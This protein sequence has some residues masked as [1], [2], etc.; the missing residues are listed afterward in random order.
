MM[1]GSQLAIVTQEWGHGV[2]P[3]NNSITLYEIQTFILNVLEDEKRKYYR[4]QYRQLH[5]Q[6]YGKF[7]LLHIKL[8]GKSIT[9][10]CSFL[11]FSPTHLLLTPLSGSRASWA[12]CGLMN[13]IFILSYLTV[14]PSKKICSL[15]YCNIILQIQWAVYQK[16]F[17]WLVR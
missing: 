7:F 9:K 5:L 8:V 12:Y 16:H 3:W 6:Y 1:V 4:S 17:Q 11:T 10:C 14:Y 15:Y 13:I 2:I